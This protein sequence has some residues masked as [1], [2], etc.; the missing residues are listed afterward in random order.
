[1][2]A[3]VLVGHGD[4]PEALRGSVGMIAGDRE[5]ILTVSLAA[6]DGPEQLE[7]K[8]AALDDKLSGAEH[9]QVF[10][11]LFGGSPCNAALAR[12]KDDERVSIVSGANLPMVVTAAIQGADTATLIAEGRAGIRDVK[13]VAHGEEDVVPTSPSALAAGPAPASDE[14]QQ[15]VGV[16]VDARGIHGQVA[17]AWVPRLNVTRVVVVDGVA[18]HDETQ[19]MALKMAKPASVKLSILTPKK[20]V[21]RLRDDH[22]YPGD[23][24]FVVMPRV[25]TLRELDELGYDFDVVNMG[26]VPNRPGT[27]AYAKTVHLTDDEAQVVREAAAKGTRFTQRQVPADPENDFVQALNR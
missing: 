6:D 4:L 17:T 7:Q 19:K 22:G 27:V 12:Y 24:I 9:I 8:L 11:D 20:A 26:N 18:V 14:P 15:I 2:D 5:D 16:R 1:M 10:A 3:I 13:A 21:E 23:R 25:V